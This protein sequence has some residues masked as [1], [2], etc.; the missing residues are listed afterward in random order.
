M[1]DLNY[2][3]W[4]KPLKFLTKMVKFRP[5][6]EKLSDKCIHLANFIVANVLEPHFKTIIE[7]WRS[8]D[9]RRQPNGVLMRTTFCVYFVLFHRNL[10][11]ARPPIQPHRTS[12]LW[13]NKNTDNTYMTVGVC[14]LVLRAFFSNT[15][16]FRS[17][18]GREK[19]EQNKAH[20]LAIAIRAHL[21]LLNHWQVMNNNTIIVFN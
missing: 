19:E 21:V 18:R 16:I 15:K 17:T 11:L 7:I 4:K 8:N 10:V 12:S 9:R 5:F 6:F 14:V 13:C 3:S 2:E 20:N 1:Y